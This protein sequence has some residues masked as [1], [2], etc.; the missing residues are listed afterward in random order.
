MFNDFAS[1]HRGTTVIL[2]IVAIA[3]YCGNLSCFSFL[4]CEFQVARCR[5]YQQTML[6]VSLWYRLHGHVSAHAKRCR[7]GMWASVYV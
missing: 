4:L 6:Y 3:S 7:A 1:Y 2:A 5:T